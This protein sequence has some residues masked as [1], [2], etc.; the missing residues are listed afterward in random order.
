E[1][2]E[3]ARMVEREVLVR[4]LAEMLDLRLVRA[5]DPAGGD[6]VHWLEG[7]GDAVLVGEPERDHVELQRPYGS[8]YQ[9]V[10]AQRAEQLRRAFLAE[11]VE[12]LLQRLHAQRILEYRAPEELGREVR[13]ARE[14]DRLALGEGVA[15][16]DRAVV[17]QADDVAGPGLV[18]LLAVRGHESE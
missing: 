7:A 3:L 16:V 11:L 12:A 10:V 17:V 1:V 13:D 8:E 4:P 5:V 9:V 6:D 2:D 14:H 18:G 15:D